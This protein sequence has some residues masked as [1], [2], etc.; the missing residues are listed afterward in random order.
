MSVVQYTGVEYAGVRYP[1]WAEAAGWLLSLL[2]IGQVPFWAVVSLCRAVESC[3]ELV[4]MLRGGGSILRDMLR[5]NSQWAPALECNRPPT[6][7]LD[8]D[9]GDYCHVEEIAEFSD[10]ESCYVKQNGPSEC[11]Q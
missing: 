2:L 4:T 7:A 11:S 8:A 9:V 1:A 10:I 6:V 3:Q 5:P